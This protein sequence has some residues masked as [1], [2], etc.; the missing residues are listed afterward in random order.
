MLPLAV[1]LSVSSIVQA[2]EQWQEKAINEATSWEAGALATAAIVSTGGGAAMAF[3][4]GVAA[5]EVGAR[6]NRLMPDSVRNTGNAF[7]HAAHSTISRH[8][9]DDK[10]L[11]AS[12]LPPTN[13]PLRA[14]AHQPERIEALKSMQHR[15][16]AH[17]SHAA[18]I[19]LFS[20]P[21]S[22]H[23]GGSTSINLKQVAH[24]GSNAH[25]KSIFSSYQP[26]R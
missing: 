20:R 3:A 15:E 1:G 9:W 11:T 13:A 18:S 2:R 17:A 12:L 19:G 16:N 23:F 21:A 7:I 4:G 24:A 22:E 26:S 5:A 25:A 6:L 10:A 8:V 14:S